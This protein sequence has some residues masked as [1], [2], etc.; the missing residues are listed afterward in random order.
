MVEDEGSGPGLAALVVV[1]AKPALGT[2]VIDVAPSVVGELPGVVEA[3]NAPAPVTAP[4]AAFPTLDVD[5]RSELT[6]A[7]EGP[8]AAP[9]PPKTAKVTASPI[10]SCTHSR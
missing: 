6:G 1:V 10:A 4:A 9:T 2:V 8:L 3:E 5:T 7:V